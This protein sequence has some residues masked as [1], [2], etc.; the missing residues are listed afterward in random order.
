MRKLF[1][2]SLLACVAAANAQFNLWYNGDF[3]GVNGRLAQTTVGDDGWVFENFNVTSPMIV[4]EMFGNYLT[5]TGPT[6]IG[7]TAS[8]EIRTG[9]GLGNPGALHS[10]GTSAV[11]SNVV[12]GRS[13][14]GITEHQVTIGGLNILLNPGMYWMALS[15]DNPGGVRSFVSS[16]TGTDL[17]PGGDPNPAPNGYIPGDHYF[18]SIVFGS[19]YTDNLWDS[20]YGMNGVPEPGTFVAIGLGLAGLALARRRK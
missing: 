16:T 10:S 3:D 4:T 7:P 15:L 8:Y 20:S 1:V 17:G 5:T 12:T 6:S 11:I 9:V 2:L 19:N 18:R 14:F 13:G